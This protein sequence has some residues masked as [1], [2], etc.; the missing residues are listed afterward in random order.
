M[1][2]LGLTQSE[3]TFMKETFTS[4][5]ASLLNS[6]S[7]ENKSNTPDFILAQYLIECLN[8]FN[9]ATNERSNWY[10]RN[11]DMIK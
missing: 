1:E 9:K 6:V 4:K 7:A 11:D 3:P 8:A 10:S 2:N 5:L